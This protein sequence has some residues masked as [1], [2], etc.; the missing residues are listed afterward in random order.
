MMTTEIKKNIQE[1]ELIENMEEVWKNIF[2]V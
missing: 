1:Q 2:P